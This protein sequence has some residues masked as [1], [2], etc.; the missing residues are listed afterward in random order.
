MESDLP[1][2]E[3]TFHPTLN[4]FQTDEPG[5]DM[6]TIQHHFEIP[7]LDDKDLGEVVYKKGA[8]EVRRKENSWIYV[9]S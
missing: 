6:I 5:E 1:I 3:E 9:S 8:W 7:Y 4:L 2:T